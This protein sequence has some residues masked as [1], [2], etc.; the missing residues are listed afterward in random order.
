MWNP[1]ETTTIS[2]TRV[3]TSQSVLNVVL[4]T[5]GILTVICLIATVMFYF[6]RRQK[7]GVFMELPTVESTA[8]TQSHTFPDLCSS[9]IKLLEIKAQGRF[10]A[11]WRASYC[12]NV[13]AVKIF[14][15]QDYQSWMV[16]KKIFLLPHMKHENLLQFIGVEEKGDR[17]NTEYWL[18][19]SYH[20]NGSLYDYLKT[21]ILSWAEL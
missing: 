9:S 2:P 4:T 1:K 19:T 13:I 16:E 3:N 7:M 18:L 14:P 5:L 15:V 6:Y 17:F 20:E 10:G 8:L 11:V 21:N 12:S